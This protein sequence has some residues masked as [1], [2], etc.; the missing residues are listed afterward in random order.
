MHKDSQAN[1]DRRVQQLTKQ[2]RADIEHYKMTLS[3]QKEAKLLQLKNELGLRLKQ[4]RAEFD[5]IKVENRQKDETCRQTLRQSTKTK[6]ET[7]RDKVKIE[8]QEQL[9]EA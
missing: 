5:Q 9:R 3:E 4:K 6:T 7:I 1:I 2:M 8:T